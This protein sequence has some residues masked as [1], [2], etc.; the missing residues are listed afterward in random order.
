[1]PLWNLAPWHP[2]MV[3]PK[4]IDIQQAWVQRH[5]KGLATN[6]QWCVY[7]LVW[8]YWVYCYKTG[9]QARAFVFMS[10]SCPISFGIKILSGNLNVAIETCHLWW[11][12]PFNSG[13]FP[14]LN[15]R[16]VALSSYTTIAG[17]YSLLDCRCPVGVGWVLANA[18]DCWSNGV[19]ATS[20][21]IKKLIKPWCP[22]IHVNIQ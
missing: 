19:G 20:G 15:Y 4:S 1:M 7:P 21:V 11:I 13:D 18:P 2:K 14:L 16:R 17:W 22:L 12:F 10:N 3:S 9:V 6:K 8:V 5:P